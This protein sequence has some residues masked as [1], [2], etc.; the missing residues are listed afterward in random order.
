MRYYFMEASISLNCSAYSKDLIEVIKLFKLIGWGIY[1]SKGQVEYL[2]VDDNDMYNWQCEII[3]ELEL[4]NIIS[5]K[6]TN[7]E[8]VGISLFY[9]NSLEGISLLAQNTDEILLS[10]ITNRKIIKNKNTDM[11]CYIK[12]IIYKLLNLNVR[13][14]S[15]RLEEFED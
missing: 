5:K 6:I 3:S 10:I 1:N 7:G 13:I 15:Y 8:V 4:Y 2:P 14:L 11:V 12:N 9:N